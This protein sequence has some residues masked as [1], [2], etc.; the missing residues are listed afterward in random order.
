[1]AFLIKVAIAGKD[2]NDYKYYD[3]V[4]ENYVGS[5]K[6][7]SVKKLTAAI[8]GQKVD[9]VIN[10]PND[11]CNKTYVDSW[12]SAFGFIRYSLHQFEIIAN[13]EFPC[14]FFDAI[15]QV[16]PKA[17]IRYYCITE[18]CCFTNMSEDNPHFHKICLPATKRIKN[19]VKEAIH[20]IDSSRRI[21]DYEIWLVQSIED[22]PTTGLINSR[23]KYL[24][25][26]DE[27]YDD[28]D[29]EV[30]DVLLEKYK[31]MI[32]PSLPQKSAEEKHVCGGKTSKIENKPR[33]VNKTSESAKFQSP[34]STMP[35]PW[36]NFSDR[37]FPA[38]INIAKL[39]VIKL[40]TWT[41][42]LLNKQK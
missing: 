23:V 34:F 25:N 38:F 12:T 26:P 7:A 10:N 16:S 35:S 42:K 20:E 27:D 8:L 22:Y 17:I 37:N 13:N 36:K 9:A 2:D 18:S 14:E 32:G 5:L 11:E 21:T 6:D 3:N 41:D 15:K 28:R 33:I 24:W 29:L 40:Q 30:S 31:M 39:A 4:L 19:S 1:M